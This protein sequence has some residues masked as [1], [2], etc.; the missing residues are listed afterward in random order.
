MR[1]IWIVMKTTRAT[2]SLFNFSFK[3]I[4][5][6]SLDSLSAS[7]NFSNFGSKTGSKSKEGKYAESYK[8]NISFENFDTFGFGEDE[9]DDSRR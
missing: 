4:I 1:T 6:P 3:N 8:V 5:D 7:R 9:D 2:R